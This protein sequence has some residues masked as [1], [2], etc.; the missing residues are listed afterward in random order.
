MTRRELN[1]GDVVEANVKGQRFEAEI[2]DLEASVYRKPIKVR[3]LSRHIT[4]GFLSPRQ[5]VRVVR[6]AGEQME[7]VT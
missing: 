4:W 1:P 3:P 2:E 6:R 7:L 5:V